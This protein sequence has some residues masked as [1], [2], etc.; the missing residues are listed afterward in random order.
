MQNATLWRALLGVENAIV[1][2]IDYDA[3]QQLLIASVRPR[4]RARRRCGRC[5]R[6]APAFDH[7]EGR[8]RWRALDFGHVQVVLEAAAP[9]V[10]CRDH[11]PTVAQVPWARHNAGHTRAFDDQ[12]AWLAT[13]CSKKAVTE[14]M[15][16]AWRTVGSIITRVW[17]DTQVLHDQFADLRRI[18]VDEISYKRG[19]KYLT[20][21]VDHDTGRLVWVAPGR[22]IATLDRFFVALEASGAGRCAAITHVSADGADWIS[23]SVRRHCPNAIR[24]ADPFHI[25][26]W[27]GKALDEVRGTAA[28]DAR[29][30]ARAEPKRPVGRPRKDA[31]PR[32]A[33][34][35]ATALKGARYSLLKNPE[36]L[37]TRQATRLAWIQTTDPRLY[38]AYLLKE[39]LRAV[40]KLDYDEAVEALEAWINW[41]RRSRLPSF[42][43]LQKKIVKHRTTILAAIEHRLSN[44]RI[45]SVNTKIRLITRTAF[46][47]K[48][49]EPLIALAMLNLGGHRPVLPGRT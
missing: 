26:Q 24:C 31:P 18:G 47:F 30:R 20:V 16:I 10:N 33:N 4:K 6:T 44:G 41:A 38:R 32:P 13:Q 40:F 17:A 7:G 12:V 25:V 22:D 34:D 39:G 2:D 45:E 19:Q 14:L 35:Y 43:K 1:E 36:N 21:V 11:G 9:R 46:G 29:R 42:V 49:P 48:S 28:A 15:R 8:R 3:E 27:A 5:S 23:N 37:T